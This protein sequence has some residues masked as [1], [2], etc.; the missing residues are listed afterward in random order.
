MRVKSLFFLIVLSI[1]YF[2]VHV[3][4]EDCTKNEMTRISSLINN[5]EILYTHIENNRFKINIYNVPKELYILSPTY[6]RLYPDDS[7]SITIDNYIGGK[8]YTFNIFSTENNDCIN[9]MNY[10]KTIYVKKYNLYADKDICMDSKYKDFK[11]CNKWYQGSITDDKFESEIKKYEQE[12]VQLELDEQETK[13][14]DNNITFINVA[15]V[16]ASA[17]FITITVFIIK[18]KRRIL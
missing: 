8:S 7:N 11:Y 17:L 2:P 15:I 14:S 3:L 13:K 4:A 6:E 1:F 9:S 5:I 18:R 12:K 16:F 10:T